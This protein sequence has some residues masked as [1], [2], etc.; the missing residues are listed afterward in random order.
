MI[1]EAD[2]IASL[3]AK[4]KRVIGLEATDD[5]ADK[6][7][8]PSKMAA[9]RSSQYRRSQRSRFQPKNEAPVSNFKDR[10]FKDRSSFRRKTP[11]CRGCGK[12]THGPGKK[13]FRTDCPAFGKKC[14]SCGKEDHFA[15]VCEQ[16]KF[17]ANFVRNDDD[18]TPGE[19][20]ESEDECYDHVE[21]FED[22]DASEHVSR[23]VATT[24]RDF[25]RVTARK[26]LL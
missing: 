26:P 11:R 15:E 8:Q 20:S 24:L 23:N 2:N 13:M 4:I 3:D 21:E 25:R 16:R 1:S 18:T 10:S 19:T 9:M 22:S 6:I 12:S 17:H 7:C 14:K 5:A